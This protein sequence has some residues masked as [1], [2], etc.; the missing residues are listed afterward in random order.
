[1]IQHTYSDLFEWFTEFFIVATHSI[2]YL[3]KIY[4]QDSFRAVRQ[5]GIAVHQSRHPKVCEYIEHMAR[6]CMEFVKRGVVEKV[7][8]VVLSASE[9]P[10][11]RFAFDLRDFPELSAKLSATTVDEDDG[12]V[13]YQ[14]VCSQY[15]ACLSTLTSLNDSFGELPPDC[16]FSI[17]ME[18]KDDESNACEVDPESIWI[19]GDGQKYHQDA[20]SS[21][22]NQ[23]RPSIRLLPVRYVESGPFSFNL[24]LEEDK[25]KRKLKSVKGTSSHGSR[26]LDDTVVEADPGAMYKTTNDFEEL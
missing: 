4:P 6:S 26:R 5:Y 8:L 23:S 14:E 7:S 13:T 25:Q 1:M 10:L 2:L 24:F 21:S 20:N 15:R 17:I 16:T 12:G 22:F 9:S 11:E 18:T 19:A 3:R